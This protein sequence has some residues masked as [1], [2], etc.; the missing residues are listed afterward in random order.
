MARREI[1]L[2]GG[3][4]WGVEAYYKKINGIVATQ[5]GYANGN[6]DETNYEIIK[7]T[8]HA[9]T[10]KIVYDDCV[11]HLAEIL[12][13]LYRAINPVSINRQ[14]YDIGRQYRTGIFYTDDDSQKI[15]KLSLDILNENYNGK[16]AILLEKLN[17]FVPAEEYHQDYLEKN[18]D[19]YCHINLSKLEDKLYKP[20]Y[21]LND[22]EIMISYSYESVDVIKH[23]ATEAPFS[24]EYDDFFK[25]G[26]YVDIV[27]GTPLFSSADKYDAGCGWPSF[28]MAITTDA[29]RYHGDTS[30]NM[31]RTEVLSDEAMSHLGHV[32]S[33]GPEDRGG[34]RYCINSASLS[35]IPLEKMREYGYKELI[36]YVGA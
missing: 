3:C 29:L 16:V 10:V 26:I 24:G 2:A 36:P 35:F 15:A 22:N 4:F 23:K 12:D 34:L 11:I 27:D 8:G 20:K 31:R 6:G 21:C 33:D 7:D 30:F 5:V 13:R 18:P 14:G 17:N 1:Y 19:G 32:F 25:K 28:T 9:E